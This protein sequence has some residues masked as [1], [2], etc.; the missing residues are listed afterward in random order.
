MSKLRGNRAARDKQGAGELAI[1][2]FNVEDISGP[3]ILPVTI[4]SIR[5][6]SSNPLRIQISFKDETSVNASTVNRDGVIRATGPHDFDRLLPFVSSS[7]LQD[8]SEIIVTYEVFPSID[9]SLNGSYSVSIEPD[10]VADVNGAFASRKG[11]IDSFSVAIAVADDV[12][13]QF[14]IVSAPD[15]IQEENNNSVALQLRYTDNVEIDASTIDASNISAAMPDGT[16]LTVSL[17][18]INQVSI[19]EKIATYRID[20]PAGGWRFDVNG[21]YRW[22]AGT[23]PVQDTSGNP[24]VIASGSF[25]VFVPI[26]ASRWVQAPTDARSVRFDIQTNIANA[27]PGW[28]VDWGEEDADENR[29]S[30]TPT[31]WTSRANR[32]RCSHTYTSLLPSYT[33]SLYVTQPDLIQQFLCRSKNVISI[34]SISSQLANLEVLDFRS[35]QLTSFP[36]F[37]KEWKLKRL[38][39]DDNQLSRIQPFP[40]EWGAT[41]EQIYASRNLLTS[42]P[43][44]PSQYANLVQLGFTGNKLN[45]AQ[46]VK[47]EFTKLER[48]YLAD[49]NLTASPVFSS[50]NASLQRVHLFTNQITSTID[51]FS[52]MTQLRDV[53]VGENQLTRAPML[54]AEMTG[55]EVYSAHNNQI[56]EPPPFFAGMTKIR[57]IDLNNNILDKKVG[58]HATFTALQELKIGNNLSFDHPDLLDEFIELNILDLRDTSYAGALNIPAAYK[59]LQNLILNGISASSVTLR[60]E[61]VEL[62]FVSLGRSP[63]IDSYTTPAAWRLI[64][65]ISFQ[66]IDIDAALTIHPE[67]VNLRVLFIRQSDATTLPRIPSSL[68]KLEKIDM[69]RSND[70]ISFSQLFQDL[71]AAGNP[72]NFLERTL[73]ISSSAPATALITD[74]DRVDLLTVNWNIQESA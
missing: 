1:A 44:I 29:V 72:E 70:I 38:L 65:S 63:N 32:F 25:Q 49:N 52:T 35:N 51:F 27:D 53:Y 33:I 6:A 28:Y 47:P 69:T 8:A 18:N 68:G 64:E 59:K 42:L 7:T 31:V 5:E 30:S 55:L 4:S 58:L 3:T 21:T 36:D 67:Y 13:P 60:P 15:I 20:P 34:E 14:S 16:S 56:T 22:G 48:V 61:W 39:L 74:Q 11:V 37:S 23:S 24:V 40:I 12:A 9:E 19:A 10:I 54:F 50:Q 41:M 71:I 66:E 45:A 57:V 2:T 26:L 43:D 73:T 17:E 62:T 46:I